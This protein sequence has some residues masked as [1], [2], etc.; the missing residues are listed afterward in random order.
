MSNEA[1][2]L[3]LV[4]EKEGRQTS[5]YFVNQALQG[6][7]TKYPSLERPVLALIYAARRLRW[8]FQEHQIEVLTNCLIKYIL[9]K[10]KMS[11]HLA[12]YAIELG[13]HDISYCP[14]TN[15][16]GKVLANFLLEIPGE[17]KISTLGE[18]LSSSCQ[19][20]GS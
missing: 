6:P 14:R 7:E 4:V 16:K 9:L 12:K 18:E 1:I 17:V 20:K 10:P 11:G 8:Y 15:I 5:V 2:S 19:S 3:V 13:K